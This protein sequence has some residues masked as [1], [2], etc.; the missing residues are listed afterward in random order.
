MFQHCCS[1]KELWP[2][3][4][5]ANKLLLHL[6]LHWYFV[7]FLGG[8]C[9]IPTL[10]NIAMAWGNG[11]SASTYGWCYHVCLKQMKS[12]LFTAL[13]LKNTWK[14]L[15]K[16]CT[17]HSMCVKMCGSYFEC[18]Q[19]QGSNLWTR[20]H[21][22]ALSECEMQDKNKGQHPFSV[23]YVLSGDLWP[24]SLFTFPSVHLALSLPLSHP[25]S[26]PF[27]SLCSSS[28]LQPPCQGD[29]LLCR[30]GL[31]LCWVH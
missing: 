18:V 2:V 23:K 20:M 30:K 7:F 27:T 17:I 29:Q 31:A 1:C 22:C 13:T 5:P 24:L 21:L 6:F 25:D 28:L 4:S 9:I 8:F 26:L 11:A 14:S 15:E 10:W 19:L 16:V 12:V 3:N